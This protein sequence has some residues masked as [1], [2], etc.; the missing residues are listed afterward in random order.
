MDIQIKFIKNYMENLSMIEYQEIFNIIKKS[1]SNY[2]KNINGVFIDLMKLELTTINEI[3]NYMLYCKKLK[4]NMVDFELTK[5]SMIKENLNINNDND[6]DILPK[7]LDDETIVEN[8][9]LPIKNKISSTMK[10]YILKKKL[11]KA[12]SLPDNILFDNIDMDT[13]YKT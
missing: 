2:S 10:F 9:P 5:S 11:I 3:Y 6:N 1:N 13:P 8:I 4:K 7:L 12:I